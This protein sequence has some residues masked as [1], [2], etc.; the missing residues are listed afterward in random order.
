MNEIT[1]SSPF[2]L[3]L[4]MCF[5]SHCDLSYQFSCSVLLVLFYFFICSIFVSYVMY[6]IQNK[7]SERRGGTMEMKKRRFSFFFLLDLSLI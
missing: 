3:I 2:V 5:A 4:F 6:M 7:E 1:F